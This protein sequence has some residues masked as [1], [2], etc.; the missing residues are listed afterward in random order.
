LDNFFNDGL[1]GCFAQK[2]KGGLIILV[3]IIP[4]GIFEIPALLLSAA[5]GLRIERETLKNKEERNLDGELNKGLM[6][7]LVLILELLLIAAAVESS[8]FVATLLF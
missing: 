8:S 1:I 5:V 6:V 7:F 4:H 3:G 2:K